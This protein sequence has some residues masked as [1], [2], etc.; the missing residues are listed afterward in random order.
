MHEGRP[1]LEWP[2]YHE[3]MSRI[4]AGDGVWLMWVSTARPQNYISVSLLWDFKSDKKGT[5]GRLRKP[6]QA[7]MLLKGWEVFTIKWMKNISR[8]RLM[9]SAV[10]AGQGC[11]VH[12]KRPLLPILDT[13]TKGKLIIIQTMKV[14]Y[15]GK[16]TLSWQKN[17]RKQRTN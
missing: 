13:K 2:P 4:W 15:Y 8:N 14:T 5:Y 6:S 12:N 10:Q 9:V 1:S 7:E 3:S 16:V 17:K 11:F